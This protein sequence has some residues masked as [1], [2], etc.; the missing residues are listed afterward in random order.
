VPATKVKKPRID[1]QITGLAGE[2]YVAAELL[3]R[4]ILASIT[5]G[6]AKAIDILAFN[7][8]TQCTLS[9][10][11]KAI[12]QMNVFPIS[13]ARVSPVHMYVFVVINPPGTPPRFFIVPVEVLANE[14]DRFSKWFKDPKFPGFNAKYLLPFEDA[15]VHFEMP[16]RPDTTRE[17]TRE[18]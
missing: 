2:F 6:S 18:G 15:W 4:D 12:R 16:P 8:R 17:L 9:V 13:H 3:K 11:V 10:Q 14:P 5:F 1:G 7:P